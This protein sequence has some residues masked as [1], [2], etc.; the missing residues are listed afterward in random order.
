MKDR[1]SGMIGAAVVAVAVLVV[2]PI[3]GATLSGTSA[4]AHQ[5]LRAVGMEPTAKKPPRT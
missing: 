5:S 2:T 4:A 1:I 3:G